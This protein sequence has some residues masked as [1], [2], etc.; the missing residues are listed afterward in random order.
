[1]AQ[2]L[3]W[4]EA[5]DRTHGS[6]EARGP[7]ED[8]HARADLSSQLVVHQRIRAA[9]RALARAASGSFSELRRA[10]PS[11]TLDSVKSPD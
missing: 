11:A 3:E 8:V 6:V 9:C 7:A 4:L 5:L 10:V 1:M 2:W